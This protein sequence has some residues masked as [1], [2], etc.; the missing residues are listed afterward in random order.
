MIKEQL[1]LHG[2][3]NYLFYPFYRAI[4]FSCNK[5]APPLGSAFLMTYF[6]FR[7][8]ASDPFVTDRLSG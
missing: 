1:T 5:K 2:V 6:S 4:D 8:L 3:A 7:H